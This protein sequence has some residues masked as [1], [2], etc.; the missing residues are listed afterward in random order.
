M[1]A[2][3]VGGG[4]GG[5]DSAVGASWRCEAAGDVEVAGP[6]AVGARTGLGEG[7]RLGHVGKYGLEAVVVAGPSQDWTLGVRGSWP[8]EEFADVVMP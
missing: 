5:D 1:V 7:Q 6:R 8:A 3:G 2:G 4:G